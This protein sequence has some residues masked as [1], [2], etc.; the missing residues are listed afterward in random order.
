MKQV[1]YKASNECLLFNEIV[2]N[3]GGIASMDSSECHNSVEATS[4]SRL[5]YI[6][7]VIAIV[8]LVLLLAFWIS[9]PLSIIGLLL[10]RKAKHLESIDPVAKSVAKIAFVLSIMVLVLALLVPGYFIMV[11][12]VSRPP[13]FP[14]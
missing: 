2:S 3:L 5:A 6:S 14:S 7:L 8:A 12:N 9:I 11:A 13:Q 4:A 10:S 1:N